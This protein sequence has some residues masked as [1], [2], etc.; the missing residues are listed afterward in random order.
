M[1]QYPKLSQSYYGLLEC[2]AQDHMNFL[3]NLEPNVFLYIITSLSDGL[4][5]L[6][7]YCTACCSTL[8]HVVT[9]I[10]QEISKRNKKKPYDA[11]TCRNIV[12]VKPELWQQMLSVILNIII[13]EDCRNQWSMSRPLLG[14]ILL[15]EEYF[16]Q[17]RQTIITQQPID[18]QVT[19]NQLFDGLMQ[20]IER[21]LL[22]KNR[23][24]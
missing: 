8:D 17:L 5:S 15:N 19:M 14:L 16:N 12:E 7:A 1:Q 21:N 2:I 11:Q 13:F 3:A 24:R 4:S 18:K 22:T 9:Y 6:D 10:F 20:G 23:D